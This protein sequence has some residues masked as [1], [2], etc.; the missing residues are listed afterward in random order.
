MEK[1]KTVLVDDEAG[2]REVLFSLLE[3]YFPEIE[4][5]G[6]A[7]NVE[8]AFHLLNKLN[9]QLIFLDI[10][11]PKASGFDLLKKFEHISFEIVFVTSFDKYA[12]NAIKFSAL[13]YLLKPV[14]LG[15]LKLAIDKVVRSISIKAN[16]GIQVIN[17]LHNLESDLIDRKIAVHA[18]EKVKL[19]S[20]LNIVY[21]EGEGR[22]CHL[23]MIDKEVYTTAKNLKEFEEYFE[24]TNNFVR[25]TKDIII[26]IR[27]IRNYSKGEPCII[28][29]INGKS[30]DVARR[31]KTE[32]LEKLK[33]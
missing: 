25:I 3:K 8:E 1:I 20:E 4:V 27:H 5:V 26:N 15:D 24:S 12:I 17:L 13:D 21:V 6:Q 18:G 30:F 33:K 22:Y 28:E 16:S 19:L 14:E 29:M 23:T 31:K 2:S 10:Q 11:M 7:S 32:V 9:P